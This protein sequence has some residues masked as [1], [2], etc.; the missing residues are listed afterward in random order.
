MG[1]F[2]RKFYAGRRPFVDAVI[3]AA[4]AAKLAISVARSA[5]A[6]RGLA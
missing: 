3:Y 1:R 4:I 2:Y 6:R 5:V